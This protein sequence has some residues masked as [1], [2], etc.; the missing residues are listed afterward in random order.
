MSK[1]TPGAS[2]PKAAT[3]FTGSLQTRFSMLRVS[4]SRHDPGAALEAG[5][6][7]SNEY[8]CSSGA[9]RGQAAVY[10]KAGAGDVL[11]LI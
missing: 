2:V 9:P 5:A 4:D 1:P 3:Q 11:C 8:P 7:A 10:H 6:V